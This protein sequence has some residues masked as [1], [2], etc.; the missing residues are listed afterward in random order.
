M[1]NRGCPNG[2]SL[3]SRA[4]RTRGPFEWATL[5]STSFSSTPSASLPR[6]RMTGFS[7]GG[8]LD[9][10]SAANLEELGHAVCARWRAP[11]D[12]IWERRGRPAQHTHSKVMCWV[13]LDRLLKLHDSKH[14]RI[15]VEQ[16]R[17]ERDAIRAEIESRGYNGRIGSYV[18]VL[19]RGPVG[20]KPARSCLA[21]LCPRG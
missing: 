9:R 17:R 16:L 3:T 21:R 11:D 18:S 20:R 12:G 13:A 15:P 1:E 8:T 5:P 2:S 4:T 19:G 14:V 6:L 10:M 7:R